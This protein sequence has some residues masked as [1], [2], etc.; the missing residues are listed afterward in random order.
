M[1]RL[2]SWSDAPG[3]VPAANHLLAALPAEE[4]AALLPYLEFVSLPARTP[5]YQP[6]EPISHVYFPTVGVV[7]LLVDGIEAG[8]V[9][10]EGMIGLPIFLGTDRATGQGV[11]QVPLEALRM[12]ADDF[13]SCVDREGALHE[14]L[15]RYTH[16]LLCQ[17]SQSLAC[18]VSHA[19][20]Q[21]LCR[22]LL[23]VHDRAGTDQFP[24]TQEFMAAML[25]V[26]RASVSQVAAGLQERGLIRYQ[27][28]RVSVL[29][30]AGLE[31]AACECFLVVEA[32]W[33]RL[34]G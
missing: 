1:E 24:L 32:E 2:M 7:S 17:V 18:G 26:R 21:R 10:R 30:R 9:G 3:P 23:L 19:L 31:A 14:V 22:W 33:A 12:T 20:P 16:F 8:V 34:F 11:V 25:G 5:V 28:G 6:S 4:Q 29:D 27:R 15:L 13:R